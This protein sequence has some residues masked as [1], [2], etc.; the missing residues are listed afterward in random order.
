MA[1]AP[2][3]PIST[4]SPSRAS[5]TAR[6][7]AG[8]RERLTTIRGRSG[9]GGRSATGAG[10]AVERVQPSAGRATAPTTGSPATA[11][12]T[13][14]AQ[15]VRGGSEYSRVPSTGS[16]IHVRSVV[17]RSGWQACA[18]PSSDSTA[19]PGRTSANAAMR[20]SWDLWSPSCLSSD[21]GTSSAV[22]RARIS[23]RT[24][25]APVASSAASR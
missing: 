24:P 23:S 4:S 5:H 21:V 9:T 20:N 11:R 10:R 1:L 17:P 2:A 8:G 14:T 25:P 7:S 16:M 3:D 6:A 19:S 13:W 12:A 22:R 18:V 15:S